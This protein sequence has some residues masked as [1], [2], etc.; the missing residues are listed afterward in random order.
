MRTTGPLS[1]F[2]RS[3]Y[4]SFYLRGDN[5]KLGFSTSD[6]YSL[7]DDMQGATTANDGNWHFGCAVFDGSDKILYL[8]GQEDARVVNP[9]QG[10]NLGIG[11]TRYGFIGDGS[12]AETFNGTR[13]DCLYQGALDE[14]SIYHRALGA[15]EIQQL[16]NSYAAPVAQ[17]AAVL[18]E[19]LLMIS[20]EPALFRQLERIGPSS[21]TKSDAPELDT[22]D[23]IPETQ[24]IPEP[25]L[26]TLMVLGLLGILLLGKGRR[27]K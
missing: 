4:Y 6:R 24:P 17:A 19:S 27:L 9:H 21:S 15:E 23:N 26:L 11:V 3:E 20:D 5:G 1:I 18:S 8:D 22:A 12:E 16:Y 13:N 25:S 10:E 14:L 2:D 7:I